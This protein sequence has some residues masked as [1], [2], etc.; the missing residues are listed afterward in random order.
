MFKIVKYTFFNLNITKC[1]FFDSSYIL[2]ITKNKKY[3]LYYFVAFLYSFSS[4]LSSSDIFLQQFPPISCFISFF[5]LNNSLYLFC[6]CSYNNISLL[7]SKHILFFL[8][9]LLDDNN[10]V[11]FLAV[12]PCFFCKKRCYR[13]F[14]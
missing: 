4:C 10:P 1:Q 3:I 11:L 9:H 2:C 7:L 12:F 6:A 5:S 13:S 14:F 8:Y